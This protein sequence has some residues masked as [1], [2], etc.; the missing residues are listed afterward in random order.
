MDW[1]RVPIPADAET[2][3]FSAGLGATLATLL[4]SEAPAPGVSTGSLRPGL[5]TLGL[6]TRCDGAAIDGDDL[7]LA[8][9]WGYTQ[10]QGAGRIVMPGPGRVTE[11]PYTDAERTALGAEGKALGLSLD[12]VLSLLGG[13]TRDVHLNA[14]ASWS[15]VPARV[16]D[17]TL[18]GYQVIKKWLSYR[19]HDV[20]GRALR[21]DEAIYVSE[22]VRRIAAIL[23]LGPALDANYAACKAAAVPWKD[24]APVA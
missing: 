17:Y 19:E 23:L 11:R 14:T 12:E 1:P 8:A 4:D 24:G 6:P 15:N 21:P 16:W 3:R 22:V 13:T 5:K 9:R 7:A 18:G 2:L 20:L 10:G